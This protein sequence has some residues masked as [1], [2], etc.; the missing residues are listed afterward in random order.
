MA[1]QWIGPGMPGGGGAGSRLFDI[2][3]NGVVLARDFDIFKR[4]SGSNRAVVE[5]FHGIEPNHQGKL[6][7]SLVPNKNFPLINALEIFD[8]SR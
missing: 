1:E 3:S 2:L 7:L 8:E 5:T 6:V 4:A